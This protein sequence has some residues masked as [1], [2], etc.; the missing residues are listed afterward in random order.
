MR[1]FILVI[2]LVAAFQYWDALSAF[3][4]P[5][6]EREPQGAPQVIMFGAQWCGYCAQARKFFNAKGIAFVEYDINKS[7][8]AR[9][10]FEALGGRGVPLI[11]IDQRVIRG[12]DKRRVIAALYGR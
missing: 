9:N 4:L 5:S 10:R 12:F 8:A 6:D 2:L 1:K 3:Y 7:E 11:L